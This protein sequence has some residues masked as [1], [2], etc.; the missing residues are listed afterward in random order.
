VALWLNRVTG[1]VFLALGAR[2]AL[3]EQ[4]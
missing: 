3:S 2:L 1:S 4:H